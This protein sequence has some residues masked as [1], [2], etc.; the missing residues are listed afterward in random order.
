[1]V[2]G[3]FDHDSLLQCA[4]LAAMARGSFRG[5]V[6]TCHILN[7][8]VMQG[9]AMAMLEQFGFSKFTDAF[10]QSGGVHSVWNLL[11]L[12]AQIHTKFDRLDLWFE[13]THQVCYSEACQSCQLTHVQSGCYEVCAFYKTDERYIRCLLGPKRHVD[14]VP[15]VVDFSSEV[16]GV[17]LPDPLL[18]AL[19]AIC[20]RVA[21]MS[22]AA[23]LF[24]QLECDAELEDEGVLTFDGTYSSTQ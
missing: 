6:H 14:G 20:A 9:S 16:Q 1:M 5:T 22:G 24:D 23:E 7:E 19:R 21:H 3:M 18:L 4:G 2:S 12:E 13:S 11:S 17:S 10:K 15:V 8:S